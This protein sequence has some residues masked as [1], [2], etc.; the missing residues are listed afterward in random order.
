MKIPEIPEP[1]GFG[2]LLNRAEEWIY[3]L[4]ERGH[5]L[6]S[7]YDFGN[8]LWARL[9]FRGVRRRAAAFDASVAG[10]EG[11]QAQL[12]LLRAGQDD[13]AFATLL[14]E[15]SQFKYRPPHPLR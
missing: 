7:L 10:R 11:N 13:D 2:R 15:L 5:W 9:V 4:N 6:F 12:R 1:R 8:E 14:G 3:D